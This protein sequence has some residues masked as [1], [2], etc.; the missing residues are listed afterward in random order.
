[1]VEDRKSVALG[2]TLD[3]QS[4]WKAEINYNSFF[5]GVGTTNQIEDRDYVS[6]SISYSI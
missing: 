6:L 3:Y 1:F 2:V 4:T 5:D